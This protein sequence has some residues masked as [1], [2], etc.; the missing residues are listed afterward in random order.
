M[1][2]IILFTDL[3]FWENIE[4]KAWRVGVNTYGNT[5][6]LLEGFNDKVNKIIDTKTDYVINLW[7]LVFGKTLQEK[8]QRF[9]EVGKILK[10]AQKNI[11]HMIGNH[12]LYITSKSD[13]ERITSQ[14]M[15]L[16]FF[17]WGYKHIITDI[18]KKEYLQ[19][20]EKTLQWLEVELANTTKPCI[21]YW[22]C[23]ITEQ[24]ENL[25][26]YHKNNPEKAFLKNSK[27]MRELLEKYNCKMYISGHT[28]FE[29]RTNIHWVEH[30]TIPSFSEN[31]NGKASGKFAVLNLENLEVEIGGIQ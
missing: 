26:Y 28:H 31:V 20:P 29:Y 6:K 17:S 9:L 1:S 7:D 16:V 27:D 21:V 30:I 13:I 4:N 11:F 14:N 12:E 8:E 25:T 24:V 23:P 5:K 19:I 18:E 22:H 10:N 2:K 3:H 15:N